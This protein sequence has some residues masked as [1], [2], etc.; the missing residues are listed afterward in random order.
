MENL[1]KE[2]AQKIRVYLSVSTTLDPYE[3]NTSETMIHPIPISAIVTDVAFGKIQWAMCGVVTDKAKEIGVEKKYRSLIEKSYKLQ[4]DGEDYIGWKQ[5][6]K[7]QIREEGD[8]CRIYVYIKK[9]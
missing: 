1:F 7:M 3:K 5:N 9:S 6:S 4:I 8:Y 2:M